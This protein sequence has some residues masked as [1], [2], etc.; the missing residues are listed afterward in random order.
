LIKLL[1]TSF[2][3][4]LPTLYTTTVLFLRLKSQVTGS[5]FHYSWL[6]LRFFRSNTHAPGKFT[7]LLNMISPPAIIYFILQSPAKRFTK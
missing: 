1:D 6:R 4:E 5:V 3:R 2:S 7:A